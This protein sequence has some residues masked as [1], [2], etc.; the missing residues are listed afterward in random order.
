MDVFQYFQGE[1]SPDYI[2]SNMNFVLNVVFQFI[3]I[4]YGNK[5]GTYKFQILVA[6]AAQ[7]I[8]MLV[9][10][11][12]VYQ[13]SGLGGFIFSSALIMLLGLSNAILL[14]AIF[15]V[16]AFLPFAYIIAMS[17]GQG[18]AGIL[19]NI[20]RYCVTAGLGSSEHLSSSEKDAYYF[21]TGF[22]FFA[23]AAFLMLV[24]V[25]FVIV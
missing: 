20:I 4:I 23:V 19:M 9:L 8:I 1:Y 3:F 7:I 15:G 14:S 13:V 5:F 25:A 21:Q 16:V 24:N 11:V 6:L 17:T 22:I 18:L 10:P 2:Y 12:V